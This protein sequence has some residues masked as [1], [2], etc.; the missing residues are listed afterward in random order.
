MYKIHLFNL[1]KRKQPHCRTLCIKSYMCFLILLME[2]TVKKE[3]S[4][5]L[6]PKIKKD[7]ITVIRS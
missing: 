4:S 1:Q 2:P 3:I 6:L 5:E 7:Y